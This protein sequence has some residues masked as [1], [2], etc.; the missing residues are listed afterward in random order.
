MNVKKENMSMPHVLLT[1]QKH[2]QTAIALEHSTLPPYLSAYWSIHGNSTHAEHSKKFLL[3]V[4]QEEMLHM[5]MACNILNA[6]GGS[7]VLNDVSLLPSFPCELPGH[8][9]TNN[10]FT[11]H[12]NKCCPHAI[13][14]FLKIEL[15][16]EMFG[17]KHHEDGWCTI[18]EFYDEIENLIKH[19]SLSDSDFKGGKQIAA[20]F[21]PAKGMLYTVNC[22]QDALNALD[23]II[24]Q[25]E[26]HSGKLHD[27][28][29]QLTHYWKFLSIQDLMQN[30]IWSYEEE[31]LDMS[32][33]PDEFYFSEEAKQRNNSFNCTYSELLDSMQVAFSSKTP[34]FDEAIGI[35]FKLKK[36][37]LQLMK[38]P[39]IGKKGNAGPT[40]KYIPVGERKAN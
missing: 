34:S 21:N 19:D 22:K 12:L 29:H 32:I 8:S 26:G 39:L 13:A 11:V 30:D 17:T 31:V 1:L 14:D 2:L 7:P 6:L 24:D 10:A 38:I 27:K 23:E 40:F 36:P 9:K 35:M 16:E 3:S 4:I 28:D 25:G 37:A 20:S 5:A 33:D 15:P 18:G